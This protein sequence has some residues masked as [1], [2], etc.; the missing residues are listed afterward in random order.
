MTGYPRIEVLGRNCRMLGGPNTSSF[1]IN[2]L[3]VSL[4]AEREHCEVLLN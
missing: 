4:D 1:G 3:R 2:R